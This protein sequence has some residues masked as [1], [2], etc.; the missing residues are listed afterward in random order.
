MK[1]SE[2]LQ[3]FFTRTIAVVNQ[4]RSLGEVLI[5]Q[6]VVEKILRSL[7]PK[8]DHV[9]TAIEVSVDLS[10]YSLKEL[11]GCLQAHEQRLNRTTK[12]GLEHAFTSKLDVAKEEAGQSKFAGAFRGRGGFQ[13]RGRGRSD[14]GG[15]S[16]DDGKKSAYDGR[17]NCYSHIQCRHCKKFGHIE[18]NCWEKA[19]EQANVAEGKEKQT[20]ANL[21]LTCLDTN[22]IR[23]DVWLLDSGCSNHMTGVKDIF[24]CIDDSTK[25]QVQLGDGKRVQAEGKGV[26]TVKLKSGDERQ[27]H[28]VLYIPGLAH[29]L[30][31]IGQLVQKG[32]SITFL[33]NF[34]EVRDLDCGLVMKVEMTAN[35]MF[36]FTFS[37][38]DCALHVSTNSD[39]WLWHMRYG[40]LHFSGLKLLNQKNMVIG[41][42]CVKSVDDVCEGCI[43]GKQHRTSFPVKS[44]W[45]AREPL[46]LV[47]AD[48]CGPMRTL[49]MGT[50]KYFL[51]FIDD[52]SRKSWVYF[53]KYKSEA[54][55]KFLIFKAYVEKQS[56]YNIK[57]LRI[58]RG[59]EFLSN[60]FT[61]FCQ[62]NGVHRELISS[63]AP[64]QNGV[65]K[66]EN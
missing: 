63:Y 13:G 25:I 62:A 56:G 36:P 34:C 39:S 2:S 29:N 8:F 5:D 55:S 30:L 45:R 23:D 28:D 47:H 66:R 4:I 33:N 19:K 59:G 22:Q 37:S 51:L 43:Y 15:R 14:F 3:V 7:T 10:T 11:M 32:Y 61:S 12:N 40:H 35:N 52:Y 48:I 46:Q 27:I 42:P 31:S 60:K 24:K 65:T 18:R 58:D 49:L 38:V 50:S 20:E 1:N 16:N 26:I 64:Q 53:L 57:T 6:K 9:V 44:T 21:F 54:F 41:L 17:G